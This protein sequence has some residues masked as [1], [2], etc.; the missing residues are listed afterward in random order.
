MNAN[1]TRIA[2]LSDV[3]MLDAR[4][5]RSGP[6]WSMR[7]RFLS[8]GR[9]LDVQGRR[10]KLAH[11]LSAARRVGA[12]HVVISGDLTEVG[13]PSEYESLA[14]VLHES[15]FAPGNMT[16]VPGNHD[17]YS[18][19]DGWRWALEGPLAA[20]A[21]T[22]ARAHGAVVECA[23]LNLLP[24]DVTFHQPVTRSAG[25]IGDQAL[26]MLE[27]RAGDPAFRDRP[28]VMVQHHPPFV[29]KTSALHWI[30]GL[31][32]AARLMVLLERFRHLFV[33]H[34]HLHAV[35]NRVVG[36]GDARVLGATAVVDDGEAP[37]V[38][39]FDVREGRLEAAGLVAN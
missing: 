37:R 3:H 20:F 5:G 16:L 6:E 9:P 35:V 22:S 1:G 25:L 23:G 17:L 8:F 10:R 13:S 39:I 12:G 34:G 11:A 31:I 28:L 27:R 7:H 19:P 18:M 14:E 21:S 15:S 38:R 24:V 32:G 4:S 29:R 26:S 33:L 36:C 30:D 2:H